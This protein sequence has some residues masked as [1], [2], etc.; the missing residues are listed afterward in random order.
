[1]LSDTGI[2]IWYLIANT[3]VFFIQIVRYRGV[4]WFIGAQVGEM[5]CRPMSK[6]M[7]AGAPWIQPAPCRIV[8]L[9]H[10]LALGF[11]DTAKM[12]PQAQALLLLGAVLAVAAGAGECQLRDAAQKC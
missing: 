5:A 2:Y 1:M 3:S 8:H 9:V 12:M 7:G 6:D 4:D 11:F 10:D